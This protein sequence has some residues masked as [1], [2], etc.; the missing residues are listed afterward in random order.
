MRII[1]VS[2][3]FLFLVC[4]CVILLKQWFYIHWR[5]ELSICDPHLLTSWQIITLGCSSIS[6]QCYGSVEDKK[7]FGLLN[8]CASD[9]KGLIG[10]NGPLWLTSVNVA[11]GNGDNFPWISLI[12]TVWTRDAIW[13]HMSGSTLAQ[14]MACSLTA[15]SHYPNQWYIRLMQYR[16]GTMSSL[17]WCVW[18]LRLIKK[19]PTCPLYLKNP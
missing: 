17:A 18:S 16:K 13:V 14:I 9:G 1:L 7:L 4:H 19:D 2:H 6:N 5:I 11:C 8:W 12:N 10:L 3:V 15:P